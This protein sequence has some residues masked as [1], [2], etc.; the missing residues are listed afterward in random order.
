MDI[1]NVLSFRSWIDIAQIKE[2]YHQPV[3]AVV[4][5]LF[6]FSIV[7]AAIFITL[8]LYRQGKASLRRFLSIWITTAVLN[9][10]G[11]IGLPSLMSSY[12]NQAQSPSSVV[13][14]IFKKH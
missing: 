3:F 13:E 4:T 1:T 11:I 6:V 7:I 10:G 12:L 8:N 9:G 14:N 5:A 2:F